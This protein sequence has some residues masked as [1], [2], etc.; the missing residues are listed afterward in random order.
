MSAH[1]ISLSFGMWFSRSWPTVSLISSTT[2]QVIQCHRTLTEEEWKREP[3]Y[4]RLVI[5]SVV[6]IAV[7]LPSTGYR[8]LAYTRWGW[9][10]FD[11]TF[12]REY[13]SRGSE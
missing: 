8:L 2:G 12:R 9:G 10:N 7:Q 5:F 1:K 13:V 6:K 4:G 3:W 11:I